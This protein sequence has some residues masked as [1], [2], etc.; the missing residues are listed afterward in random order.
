MKV[1]AVVFGDAGRV[2][3]TQPVCGSRSE[4]MFEVQE[5][6]VLTRFCGSDELTEAFFFFG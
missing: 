2:A 1:K 4:T 5:P 6:P 3:E